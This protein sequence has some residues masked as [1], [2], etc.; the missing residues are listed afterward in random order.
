MAKH[1]LEDLQKEVD[2]L[3]YAW[4]KNRIRTVEEY[5][6][7]YDQ[8]MLQI[9]QAEKELSQSRKLPD[10][11]KAEAILTGDWRNIYSQLDDAHKSA[12]WKSFIK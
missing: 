12:F 5:D 4:Q 11:S 7:K 3:N 8:L 2:R 6:R 9:D 1:N 10:Y